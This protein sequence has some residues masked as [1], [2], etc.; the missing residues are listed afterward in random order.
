MKKKTHPKFRRSRS[1]SLPELQHSKTAVLNT[2]GSLE[3]KRTYEHAMNEFIAWYCSESRLAL[4]RVVVLRYRLYLEGLGLAAN[5]I[6]VRL[7]A[8]RRLAYEA[9]D[10]GL[11]S[12]ELVAGIR[13]VAGVKQLGYRMGNWLSVEQ[14]MAI[15]GNV[16]RETTRG[17]RD[18]AILALLLGC[19]LRR[20]ELAG[21]ELDQIQQRDQRWVIVDLVGK[22]SRIRT[23]P[24]P[25]WVKSYLDEWTTAARVSGGR[26]LRPVRKN[27]DV[28]G[29]RLTQNVIW[30][31][32][33]LCAKKAGINN[34]AAHDLRRSCARL[35][36]NAGGELEQ[37]QFLLGHSSVQTTERYIGCK[38]SLIKAVNDRIV[39]Q[40]LGSQ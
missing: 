28:W 5:P 18:A 16:Q 36:H 10:N 19:G 39:L 35:C 33:R 30:Y 40:G 23:V 8:I 25:F 7:A 32:V 15:L 14:G 26:L 13:R 17:K 20:S 12:P 29:R 27:G 9:A 6:N 11:L 21:L 2:L 38:Q 34:L 22:G 1:L 24:I 31:T 37:I 3:S 4:N